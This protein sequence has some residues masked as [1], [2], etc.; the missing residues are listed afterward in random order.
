LQTDLAICGTFADLAEPELGRDRQCAVKAF[1]NAL[2]G[3]DIIEQ[4][5]MRVQDA[6]KRQEIER[7]LVLLQSRLAT[8]E[9]T[10]D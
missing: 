10:F 5:V 8:L 6:T 1:N 3:Y 7:K 4:F 9:A 2:R